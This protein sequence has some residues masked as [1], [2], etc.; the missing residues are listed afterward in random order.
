VCLTKVHKKYPHLDLNVILDH[1]AQKMGYRS[2]TFEC[3][4]RDLLEG[5]RMMKRSDFDFV[6]RISFSSNYFGECL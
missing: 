1:A 3:S 6:S 2:Y 5:L 4:D